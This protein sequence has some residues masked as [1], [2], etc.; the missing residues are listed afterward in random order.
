MQIAWGQVLESVVKY[1]PNRQVR[2]QDWTTHKV[3]NLQYFLHVTART[4]HNKQEAGQQVSRTSVQCIK[5]WEV[6]R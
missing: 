6:Q 5:R 2:L 1:S 4:K 3:K